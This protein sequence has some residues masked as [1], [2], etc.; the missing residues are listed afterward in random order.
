MN[1]N[2]TNRILIIDDEPL[3]IK[4]LN[5][6]LKDE[7]EVFFTTKSTKALDLINSDNP[8][9]LILLDIMMPEIDGYEICRRV[10]ADQKICHI[11]IIFITAK[12]NPEEESYGFE[13]GAV[14]Y[15]KKPFSPAVV[16]MR[17]RSHLKHYVPAATQNRKASSADEI[18]LVEDEILNIRI[19]KTILQK[20][21][22]PVCAVQS[23]EEAF[24]MLSN[25]DFGLVLLD[26][27]LPDIDGFEIAKAIR[28][29]SRE[30]RQPNI[31]I[32][33]L[34]AHT[35]ESFREKCIQNGFNHFISKPFQA[36]D[37]ENILS[38][39]IAADSQEKQHAFKIMPDAI[40]D[41]NAED[42]EAFFI[43][44]LK[45]RIIDLKK[46]SR[47]L[48]EIQSSQS[49][50]TIKRIAH[51]LKGSSALYGYREVS[52]KSQ[53]VEESMG[54]EFI[55]NTSDFINFLEKVA[56]VTPPQ[57]L[58]LEDGEDIQQ[59]FQDIF[60]D[61]P[62]ECIHAS[63]TETALQ[64]LQ[65][66]NVSLI[67]SDLILPDSDGRYFI[68]Q[69]KQDPQTMNIPIV[70]ISNTIEEQVKRECFLWGAEFFYTKPFDHNEFKSTI[71]KI[72][73]RISSGADSFQ[74]L[75]LDKI[76]F[77]KKYQELLKLEKRSSL[78][79]IELIHCQDLLMHYGLQ[80]SKGYIQKFANLIDN[81]LGDSLLLMKWNMNQILGL[82]KPAGSSTNYD[83]INNLHLIGQE[84]FF[85]LP[86]QEKR[87]FAFCSSMVSIE[88]K[89][90]FDELLGALEHGLLETKTD[91]TNM[92]ETLALN[93]LY[94]Q[95]KVLCVEDD[96]IIGSFLVQR[97]SRTG[98][99]IDLV[100]DGRSAVDQVHQKQYSLV[101]LDIKL[102]H[103]DGFTVLEK[104][105]RDF[106]RQNLP[107]ILLTSMGSE[108]D[109]ARGFEL[110]ANDYIQK[111][112]S[113]YDLI[114]RISKLIK[115]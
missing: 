93:T 113:P 78:V 50:T 101:I 56:L 77:E 80:T 71:T 79:L 5:E 35:T 106:D 96:E 52:E 76:T 51:S 95:K 103:M 2:K 27:E 37:I 104:I 21:G 29:Q 38:Q 14:D 57:I 12:D 11:P 59:L 87:S 63:S 72:L 64:T 75:F 61:Y 107:V 34:T 6:V 22:Y 9:D 102:P 67:I 15:I 65:T 60:K 18:L 90:M 58:L 24:Q 43:K 74:H 41:E 25:R 115:S 85:D 46:A 114:A 7:F 30:I 66:E 17:V 73:R 33:A 81:N 54:E 110:G 97:L 47:E 82:Y 69:L 3:N 10:Q 84:T 48:N 23:G 94:S 92:L 19:A 39:F 68:R 109:I 26:L 70:I 8:P 45:Q 62:F 31:P 16:K 49:E 53:T 20:L 98:I 13:I 32:I 112:F 36:S 83:A 100:T 91:S 28:N 4:T 108:K 86:D 44:N 89:F 42:M 88:S 105:R 55:Q 40:G 99:E 1:T 111:P